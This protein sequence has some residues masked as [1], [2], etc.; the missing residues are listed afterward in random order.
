MKINQNFVESLMSR[1]DTMKDP[2]LA[3]N[4]RFAEFLIFIA[5]TAFDIYQGT[6][7]EE[8][9]QLAQ[10]IDIILE[11]LLSVAGLQKKF[12]FL[13]KDQQSSS[14]EKDNDSEND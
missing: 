13:N 14:E 9:I 10:K 11:P 6:K 5:K 8:E 2:T 4:M 12:S 3:T 7:E 1:I